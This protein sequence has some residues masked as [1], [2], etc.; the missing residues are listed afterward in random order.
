[1]TKTRTQKTEESYAARALQIRSRV[2]RELGYFSPY[3]VPPLT[4]VD[5]LIG[6][7]PTIGRNTWK[8]YKNALRSHFQSLAIETDDSVAAEELRAAIAVLDAESSTG[9]MKHGTRT[10]ATKQKHFKRADFDWLLEYLIANLGRHKFANALRTWL[11]AS[12]VTGLRPSEWEHAGLTEIAGRTCLIVKNGKATNGRANGEFRTLELSLATAADME[13]IE[14]ML[15]ML[16]G[17]E[18]EMKF[19]ELQTALTHYMKRATRDCFGRRKRYPTLYSLRHQFSADAKFSG[20]SQAEVAAAL[21]HG[22]DQTAGRHY[23]RG[24][25]GESAIRVAPVCSEIQTVRAK[26]R[27]YTAHRRNTP[28]V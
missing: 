19:D 28:N 23:A 3:S 25:S 15:A 8:Q 1:M 6:R 20:L 11:L 24:V 14:E 16:E 9:A 4:I 18:P 13:A 17:Y 2:A 12:R 26:A 21:G 22:S 27:P 7:K 10:S 5:H